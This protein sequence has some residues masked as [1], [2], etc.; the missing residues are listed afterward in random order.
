MCR[1][2]IS[3]L[4]ANYISWGNS[5]LLSKEHIPLGNSR[6]YNGAIKNWAMHKVGCRN[7]DDLEIY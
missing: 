2:C 7:A 4:D 5:F 3:H 1:T 6:L